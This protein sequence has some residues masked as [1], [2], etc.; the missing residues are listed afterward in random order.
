ME[1]F[2]WQ[3]KKEQAD[4]AARASNG[5]EKTQR[6]Y[7]QLIQDTGKALVD[8]TI[9][10]LTVANFPTLKTVD[11]IALLLSDEIMPESGYRKLTEL[12]VQEIL[13]SFET[14]AHTYSQMLSRRMRNTLNML[15]DYAKGDL[16]ARDLSLWCRQSSLDY[17]AKDEAPAPMRVAL[18]SISFFQWL[19]GQAAANDMCMY[20]EVPVDE[21][22]YGD[23]SGSIG[24]D[25][26]LAIISEVYD[27]MLN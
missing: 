15:L 10:P 20:V 19:V 1:T 14:R 18:V 27:Q 2:P 23:V 8:R 22:A 17:F 11:K 4:L 5:A 7:E 13:L 6:Q 16:S 24:Y 25:V 26:I 3:A 21:K 12:M 9:S